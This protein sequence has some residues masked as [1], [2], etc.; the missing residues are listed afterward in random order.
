MSVAVPRAWLQSGVLEE[1]HEPDLV[2]Q[3]LWTRPRGPDVV[4]WTLLTRARQPDLVNQTSLDKS[5][6]EKDP[7]GN[8]SASQS[9]AYEGLRAAYI[10]RRASRALPFESCTGEGKALHNTARWSLA[11][12]DSGTAEGADETT[13]RRWL[14]RNWA[15]PRRCP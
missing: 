10:D 2:D 14:S 13:S 11:R 5:E 12:A 15:D 3:T 6:V 9:S 4:N 8:D 1:L 7:D